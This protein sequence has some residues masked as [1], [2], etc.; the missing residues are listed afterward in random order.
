MDPSSK[1]AVLQ[2]E[3]ELKEAKKK[4][5]SCILNSS[6]TITIPG[7]AIAVP[8]C[9]YFKTY[10]PL[11]ITAMAGSGLDYYWGMRKCES[12]IEEVNRIERRL[13]ESKFS[14]DDQTKSN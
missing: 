5:N 10:A 7:V 14:L 3:E 12:F 6:W 2:L 1:R 8:T 4:A 9:V 13:M 11:V